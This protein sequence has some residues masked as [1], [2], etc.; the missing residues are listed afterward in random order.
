MTTVTKVIGQKEKNLDLHGIQIMKIAIIHGDRGKKS[1]D[2]I[3][4]W[5]IYD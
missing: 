1:K 3:I 2:I 4:T 5:F